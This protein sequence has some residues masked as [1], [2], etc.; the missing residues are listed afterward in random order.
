MLTAM[1]SKPSVLAMRN[2]NHIGPDLYLNLETA[3]AVSMEEVKA[4]WERAYE[5]LQAALRALS[6]NGRLFIVFGL[7]GSGK[8]TWIAENASRM[9]SDCVFF[10]GPLPSQEKRSRA[11]AMARDA[12]VKAVAVWANVPLELAFA[13]NA[14]RRGLAVIKEEA[15]RHV[16]SQLEPPSFDEGFVEIIDI[17]NAEACAADPI[18]H[19]HASESELAHK[20]V[21]IARGSVWFM[22]ALA[23]VHQL[24]LRQWCIGAG[25][26]R[27][28]VWDFLHGKLSPSNLSDVDVAYF[29]PSDVSAARDQALQDQLR[30]LRPSVPWEV[31]NQAGVHH[32]FEGHFGHAVEPLTSLHEAVASWPEFATAV[33]L[34]LDHDNALRVIAPHGLEDLFAITIRRNPTRVSIETYRERVAQKRYAERWPLV[35]VVPC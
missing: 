6:S 14:T 21:E 29:D 1:R 34:S 19:M 28:L 23:T 27:N 31:T 16:H 4:A 5:E 35:R 11:L 15:I 2:M 9:G 26:V 24:G 10:D 22:D 17:S 3:T 18:T 25:A 13:R 20:L 32:W 7:Q 12:G 30:M 8:T 33:G